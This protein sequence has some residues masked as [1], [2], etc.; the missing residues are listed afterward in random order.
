MSYSKHTVFT[1]MVSVALIG[2][3]EAVKPAQVDDVMVKD[4]HEPVVSQPEKIE[5]SI[6]EAEVIPVIVSSEPESGG[7]TEEHSIVFEHSTPDAVGSVATLLTN[8]PENTHQISLLNKTAKHPFYGVGDK[9]G[10][11]IDGEEGKELVLKRGIT[12][13]FLV[14]SSPMHDVYISSDEMGWGAKIVKNGVDGNFTYDGKITITAN[15]STPDVVYYQCQNHKAMGARFFIVDSNDAR[16]VKGLVAQYGVLNEGGANVKLKQFSRKEVNQKLSYASL[17][18]M[19]KSAKRV[20]ISDND[21]A[22]S[23]LL[24]SKSKLSKAKELLSSGNNNAA[25]ALIDAALRDMSSAS[26]MV[27]SDGLKNEQKKRYT[28]SLGHLHQQQ[29]AHAKAVS[30]MQSIDEEIVLFDLGKVEALKLDAKAFFGK[31]TY[32][33]AVAKVL[34]ADKLVTTAINQMLDSQTVKYELNLDTPE[35]EYKYEHNRYLGYAELVPVAI[36]EKK[37]SAGQLMLLNNFFK[38]A[39]AMKLK[40]EQAVEK[41]NYPDGIRLMQEATKQVRKSLRMLGVKQ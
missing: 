32:P 26:K 15:E 31:G 12:Y 10:F 7:V 39:E 9:R 11:I 21:Q 6:V 20:R 34:E 4:L 35:G 25:M 16:D 41:G 2:C 8:L 37:P 22:K 27:P 14:N 24:S 13:T 38:K 5:L 29:D 33:A 3:G 18:G 36:E 30:R 23:L 28:D 40:G 1:V 17:V 19:S